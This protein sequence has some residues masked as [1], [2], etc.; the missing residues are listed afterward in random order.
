MSKFTSIEEL[1]AFHAACVEACRP[2]RPCLTL[3]AGSGCTASGAQAVLRALRRALTQRG[4][5]H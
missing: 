5:A 2:D 4:L 3:C 1:K